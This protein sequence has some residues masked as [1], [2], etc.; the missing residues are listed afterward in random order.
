MSFFSC[1]DHDNEAATDLTFLRISQGCGQ[2]VDAVSNAPY[3]STARA[4]AL[5]ALFMLSD[6]SLCV[7]GMALMA[8]RCL[9]YGAPYDCTQ[10]DICSS[11]GR[12]LIRE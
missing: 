11:D 10:A 2:H 9:L 12:E 4:G 7:R 1:S 6:P 5:A 8:G 3:I